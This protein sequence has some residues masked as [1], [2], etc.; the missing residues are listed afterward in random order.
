M[1]IWF[2]ATRPYIEKALDGE[3][4][5][6]FKDTEDA[7]DLLRTIKGFEGLKVFSATV[8]VDAETVKE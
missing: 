4:Y 7:C 5:F 6:T 1:R 3:I 2:I 8:V